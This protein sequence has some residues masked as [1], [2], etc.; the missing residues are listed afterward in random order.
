ML[1]VMTGNDGLSEHRI[2]EMDYGLKGPERLEARC[3]LTFS[4]GFPVGR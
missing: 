2:S 4:T 1:T 3:S